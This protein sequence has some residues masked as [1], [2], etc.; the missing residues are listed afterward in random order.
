MKVYFNW[1]LKESIKYK[2]LPKAYIN[3]RVALPIYQKYEWRLLSN[4]SNS[5]FVNTDRQVR[6]LGRVRNMVLEATIASIRNVQIKS[7]YWIRS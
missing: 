5:F 2:A 4:I 7:T 3:F 6:S 1:D